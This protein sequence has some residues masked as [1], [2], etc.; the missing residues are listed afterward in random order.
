MIK[1]KSTS[2]LLSR[3]QVETLLELFLELF[4]PMVEEQLNIPIVN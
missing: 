4:S 3:A 2:P 1:S